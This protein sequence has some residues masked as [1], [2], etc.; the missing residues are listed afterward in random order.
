MV[1]NEVAFLT[2]AWYNTYCY[3]G[4]VNRGRIWPPMTQ[5]T[6]DCSQRSQLCHE[7]KA[8]CDRGILQ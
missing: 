5:W 2:S 7:S 3:R 8:T 6:V 4:D 1:S